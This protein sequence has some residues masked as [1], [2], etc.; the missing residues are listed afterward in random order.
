MWRAS[1][2]VL[3]LFVGWC[4]PATAQ[5]LDA[6]PQMTE[7]VRVFFRDRIARTHQDQ[8]VLKVIK[9]RVEQQVNAC[10]SDGC[11]YSAYIDAIY[12]AVDV[13]KRQRVCPITLHELQGRWKNSE[14]VGLYELLSL[15]LYKR[16]PSVHQFA[17]YKAK[18]RADLDDGYGA[19]R[20]DKQRCTV[21]TREQVSSAG[22]VF[23]PGN[24]LLVLEF[25][26]ANHV[27]TVLDGSYLADFKKVE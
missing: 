27:M 2:F 4:A 13:L 26:A 18:K 7:R 23:N 19:W 20:W 5:Q 1:V 15:T 6:N 10:K 14:G 8:R 22:R 16:S 17:V 21:I 25:D 11:A 9:D 3:A 12:A 24:D